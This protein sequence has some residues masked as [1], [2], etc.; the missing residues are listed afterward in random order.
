MK[1]EIWSDF[2]CPFC[3][4][5]KNRLEKIVDEMGIDADIVMKSYELDPVSHPDGSKSVN[6]YL[7]EKY[8][9]S[10]DQARGNNERIAQMGAQE[11][12]TF[13]F[14]DMK[15]ANTFRAHK[16]FQYAK[17]LGKDKE[18][19]DLF[20][21]AVFE[22]GIFLDDSENIIEVLKPLGLDDDTLYEVMN[23]DE[24]GYKV[25][26]DEQEA[27]NIGVQGVPYFRINDSLVI[28]GARSDEDFKQALLYAK[29]QSNEEDNSCNDIGCN[30]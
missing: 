1:I 24:Y 29:T 22:K 23:G 3:Y 8:S 9:I 2:V 4:V 7:A 13:K 15:N 19:A 14:D 27:Y 25:R 20:L 18:V 12:I 16:V 17:E 5:G 28:S 26:T 30:I 6:E 10:V 21:E 11:G